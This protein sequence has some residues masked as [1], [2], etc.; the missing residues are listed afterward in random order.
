MDEHSGKR[1]GPLTWLATSRKARWALGLLVTLPVLYVASFGVACRIA[2]EPLRSR[3]PPKAWLCIYDQLFWT[4]MRLPGGGKAVF[5]F[6]IYC[7]PSGTE[8]RG[9]HLSAKKP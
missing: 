4:A 8:L 6:M 9:P 5:G 2:A 1:R 7:M 3:K